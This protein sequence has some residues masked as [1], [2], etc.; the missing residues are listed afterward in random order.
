MTTPDAAAAFLWPLS[1]ESAL[2]RPLCVDLD[3]TLVGTDTLWESLLV[4]LRYKPWLALLVP[5]WLLGGRAGFKRSIAQRVTFDATALPYREDLLDALH[6][7]KRHG[8]K[9]VLVTAADRDVATRVAQHVGIFDDVFSSEGGENLKAEQKRDRLVAAYG[10]EGFDYIGDSMADLPVFDK[11]MRGFLVGAHSGLAARAAKNHKVTLVSRRPSLLRALIKELRVHQWAKNALVVLPVVLRPGMPTL[12]VVTRAVLAALA[13]SLLA[14][15]GYVLN[16]LLD[17]PADR[18]HATKR[19]RPFASGALPVLYGPPLFLGLIVLGFA[20]AL[21]FLPKA[22][23]LMLALYFVGTVS[24]SLYFKRRLLLDVMILA[25]LYTHRILA[26]GIA[27]SIAISAWLLGFSMFLFLS[28]AFGKRYVEILQLTSD[29]KIKNRDYY[30]VDLQMVG[31]MGPA[32]GYIAALVFSL[33][34]ENG[35]HAGAY[36]EANILWL[37]VPVLLYWISRIWIITGRGQMQDDPVKYALRDKISILCAL[38]VG[39]IAALA[40]FTP[41]WMMRLLHG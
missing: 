35:A 5:F 4:L 11:A 34:V 2:A 17:L 26:G 15:A 38:G 29:E 25:G 36:R 3:G 33:Y 32:S 7:S 23:S 41:E 19:K 40:R 18:A 8:R 13:F 37:A 27:T 22:F 28:L 21:A 10:A 9:L 1:E 6:E 14:S 39:L 24:Y 31:S 30:K 20:D 16:D 12:D